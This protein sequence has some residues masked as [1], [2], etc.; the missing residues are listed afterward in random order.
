[1]NALLALGVC[2]VARHPLSVDETCKAPYDCR[3]VL[4]TLY[5]NA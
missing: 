1:M 4:L 2:Q 5:C 3:W